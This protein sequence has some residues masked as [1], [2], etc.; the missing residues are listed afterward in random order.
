MRHVVCIWMR[1]KLEPCYFLCELSH[2]QR[3]NI[4]GISARY[5]L[6]GV[7][8]HKEIILFKIFYSSKYMSLSHRVGK[9]FKI[10]LRLVLWPP[11]LRTI[12]FSFTCILCC[13]CFP[14]TSILFWWWYIISFIATAANPGSFAYFLVYLHF[15][16]FPFLLLFR[17]LSCSSWIISDHCRNPSCC[18]TQQQ[19]L[20]NVSKCYYVCHWCRHLTLFESPF[21][22]KRI[23]TSNYKCSIMFNIT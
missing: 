9:Q 19:I 1:K 8:G 22:R 20:S 6:F 15:A 7:N 13:V 16:Y 5:K 3:N 21:H 23:I 18:F 12:C 10:A 2:Q 14:V 11:C 4:S 17:S